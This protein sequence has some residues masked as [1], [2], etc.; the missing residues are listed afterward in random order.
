MLKDSEVKKL[1]KK[2]LAGKL[3]PFYPGIDVEEVGGMV[4]APR[5]VTFPDE[6]GG[7]GSCPQ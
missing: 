1:K 3:A 4:P 6:I 2:V 7:R 5:Q